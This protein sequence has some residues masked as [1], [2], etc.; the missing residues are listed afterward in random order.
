M[1]IFVC[2]GLDKKATVDKYGAEQVNIWRRSYNIPPPACD[3]TSPH[4]PN[5]DEKYKSNPVASAIRY[6]ERPVTC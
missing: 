1:L 5:N 6:I 4:S 2:T 3:S